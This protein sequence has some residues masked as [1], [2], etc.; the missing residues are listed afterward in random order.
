MSFYYHEKYGEFWNFKK[1][2]SSIFFTSDESYY[3]Y[4]ST[5]RNKK[6]RCTCVL[7]RRK[8]K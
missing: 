2:K 8:S 1:N 7:G 5:E 6:Y 4:K 3:I